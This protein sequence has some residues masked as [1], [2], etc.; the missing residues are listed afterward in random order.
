MLVIFGMDKGNMDLVLHLK[1]LCVELAEISHGVGSREYLVFGGYG[2][3][4]CCQHS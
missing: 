2:G 4:A 3:V 1:W